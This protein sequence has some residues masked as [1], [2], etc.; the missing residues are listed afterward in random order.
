[1]CHK[2]EVGCGSGRERAPR[3]ISDRGER[4]NVDEKRCGKNSFN[5]LD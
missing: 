1:V 5:I 4:R 2:G 3:E